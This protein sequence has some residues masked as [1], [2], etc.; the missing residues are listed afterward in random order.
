MSRILRDLHD[1]EQDDEI[2]RADRKKD[3]K[4]LREW[5]KCPTPEL[6]RF[7]DTVCTKCKRRSG[8]Y[9]ETTYLSALAG[10]LEGGMSMANDELPFHVWSALGLI[11]GRMR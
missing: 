3:T 10:A 2:K 6:C 7:V 1:D 9:P 4:I 11:R 8:H 5:C